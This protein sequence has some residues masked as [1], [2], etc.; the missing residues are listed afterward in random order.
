MCGK[1]SETLVLKL[2]RQIIIRELSAVKCHNMR[3][4]QPPNMSNTQRTAWIIYKTNRSFK[5]SL[6][7]LQV[8][9]FVFMALRPNA[10]HGLLVLE[11]S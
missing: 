9:V 10:G 4:D 7:E 8:V 5:H 1:N 2:V 6:S 11:V 3:L